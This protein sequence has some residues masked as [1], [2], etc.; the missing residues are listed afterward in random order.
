MKL[1]KSIWQAKNFLI[2]KVSS[3]RNRMGLEMCRSIDEAFVP[4]PI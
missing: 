2:E 4:H 1:K 3:K